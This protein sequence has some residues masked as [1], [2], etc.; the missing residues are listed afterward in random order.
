M[1]VL[2]SSFL[3]V[4]LA[5]SSLAQQPV[6]GDFNGDGSADILF[7][8]AALNSLTV[9][10][11]QGTTRL[12][13]VQTLLSGPPSTNPMQIPR[14][15][16]VGAADLDRDGHTDLLWQRPDGGR[17]VAWLMNGLELRSQVSITG[18]SWG[19]LAAT[20]DFDGDGQA[21]IVWQ[22]PQSDRT[23]VSLM[24]GTQIASSATTQPA[25]VGMVGGVGDFDLDS[26]DD[27][28]WM[29]PATRNLT[30][31]FMQGHETRAI[32]TPVPPT[33]PTGWWPVAVADY[34]AD[35][36]PDILWRRSS[37]GALV[38][39]LM[40]GLT[41]ASGLFTTPSKPGALTQVAVGPR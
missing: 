33:V 18:N 13:E 37:D 12:M 8:D 23:V 14:W 26:S 27:I 7:Q 3:C 38:V 5:S 2:L 30:V 20:G 16:A 41:R 21:D 32:A 35:G 40:D 31:W 10:L 24:N 34:N 39:W 28:L 1:R 19:R 11:M 9:W 22:D 36:R 17:V 25:G 29:D 4:L 6:K 15:R